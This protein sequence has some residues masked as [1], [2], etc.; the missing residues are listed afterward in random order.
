M[1]GYKFDYEKKVWGG[2]ILRLSPIHFRASRLF[3]ALK[4]IPN[5]KGKLLDVGCGV[6]DFVESFNYY[7]PGMD[8][9]AIDISKKAIVLAKKRKVRADFKAGDAQ[10]LPFANNTF[11]VVTCFDLI[12]H[13]RYPKKVLKEIRRV[14]KPGGIFHTFIPTE[15]NLLSIEGL[16]IKLGW[17]GK[18]IYGGHPHHFSK[19][20]V[21]SWL[22]E[23]GFK[24]NKVRWGEHFVNQIIEVL[25]FS[26]L[27]IRGKNTKITVEGYLATSK[28][29]IVIGIAKLIKSALATLS[30]I[31]TIALFWFP[32]LGVHVTCSKIE[33]NRKRKDG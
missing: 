14:L 12:E 11:D 7:R 19:R 10:K 30:F 17:K 4:E 25:Y 29:N 15:K 32:G 31:E 20:Q 5:K 2:E 9:S 21:I 26:W 3:W 16:F 23:A 24:V 33:A 27:Y 8:I 1:S 13:V 6:G 18:E 28:S 22:E